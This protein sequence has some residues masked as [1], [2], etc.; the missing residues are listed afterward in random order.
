MPW[1]LVVTNNN[2][3]EIRTSE[4]GYTKRNNKNSTANRINVLQII[5]N[6]SNPS[7]N[8]KAQCTWNLDT[9]TTFKNLFNQVKDFDVQINTIT[10]GEYETQRSANA[11][12]LNQYNMLIIGF[13]DGAGYGD[14]YDE[15]NPTNFSAEGAQSIALVIKTIKMETV[16]MII[17]SMTS[18]ITIIFTAIKI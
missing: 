12:Y 13:C 11:T 18:E 3:S 14:N 9:D 17:H 5:P 8:P 7:T 15:N 16:I 4:I 1:K 10:V 6:P 2:N